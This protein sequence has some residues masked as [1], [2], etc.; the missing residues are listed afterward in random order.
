VTAIKERQGI[1]WFDYQEAE[2][3]LDRS[4][5]PNGPAW[6]RRWLGEDFFSDVVEVIYFSPDVGDSDLAI[7]QDLP[8]LQF[9]YLGKC[10]VTNAGLEHLKPLIHL[11]VLGIAATEISD[12]AVSELQK[13]LPNCEIRRSKTD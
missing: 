9:L 7:L 5:A 1:V 2:S 8:H 3:P 10:K 12:T 13:A 6:L 11:Q 4:A